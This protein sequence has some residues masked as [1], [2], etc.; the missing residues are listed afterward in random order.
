MVN[1][2]GTLY[3]YVYES[4]FDNSDINSFQGLILH[5]YSRYIA[6]SATGSSKYAKQ[7]YSIYAY[8]GHRT[9]VE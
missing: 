5:L 4:C 3:W 9:K 7:V 1:M 8:V 6:L 2:L